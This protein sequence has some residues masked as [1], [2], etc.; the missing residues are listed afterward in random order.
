MDG[1]VHP[2]DTVA[3]PEGTRISL[4]LA[5]GAS[6]LIVVD[7]AAAPASPASPHEIAAIDLPTSGWSLSVKGHVTGGVPQIRT[8]R[9]VSLADWSTLPDLVRFSGV[10]IYSRSFK[11]PSGW[12]GK[13]RRFSLE[14]GQ[15]TTW[16]PCSVNGR[17]LP[18]V[19]SAPRSV[20]VTDA[21]RA[22]TNRI[23]IAVANV[24]QNAMIDPAN[25]AF[26]SSLLYRPD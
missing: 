18:P 22:G 19:I 20:D 26:E 21:I 2:L 15:F 9:S 13:D 11:L 16:R 23:E 7:P 14:L 17:A 8:L 25:Q 4:T 3:E 5:P 10:G 24:P 6:A 12:K 1:S